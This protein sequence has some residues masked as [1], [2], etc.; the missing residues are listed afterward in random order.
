MSVQEPGIP[1]SCAVAIVGGGT[2]GLSLATELRRLGVS[3]VVVIEREP[4]AGGAP[5]HCGHFPFGLREYGRLMKGPDYARQNVAKAQAAGVRILTGTVVTGLKPGGSLELFSS[6]GSAKLAALR[7]VLCTG[8]REASRAQRLLGGDRPPGVIA[9]GTLQDMV[10]LKGLRPFARPVILG[11]ELVSLSAIMTCRHLGIAPQAIIEEEARLIARPLFRLF[12][13]LM[14]V[15]LHTGVRDLRI[16][17]HDRVEAVSFRDR[18]GGAVTLETDGVIVS[19][20]FRPEAALLSASHLER[21]PGTGGPLI[22]QFGRCSDPS[23]FAAGNLLRAAETSGWCWREGVDTARR[24]VAD[25][26]RN[27]AKPA[28]NAPLPIRVA[29]PTLRFVV[30][31]RIAP[32]GT[33]GAMDQM[34]LGLERPFSGRLVARSG[35]K[36]LWAGRISGAPVRRVL[37]PLAPILRTQPDAPVDLALE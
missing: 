1:A 2:A 30:P 5:R 34:Q 4:E 28:T 7:V 10:Y 33:D 18:N 37:A 3:D 6:A 9:T 24:I 23:Y 31:Q 8:V 25:I 32:G 35:G 15:R 22:D 26:A 13:A 36:V 21:D 27:G 14:G 16:H 20:R 17:G 11:S 29:D 19:G 12:P